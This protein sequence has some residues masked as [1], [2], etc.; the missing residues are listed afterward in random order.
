MVSV[1][2]GG[3][4]YCRGRNT[5]NIE[6]GDKY[7]WAG[8][9]MFE[10]T[11]RVPPKNKKMDAPTCPLNRGPTFAWHAV[12]HGHWH[13]A[14]SFF[15]GWARTNTEPT[16]IIITII[17]IITIIITIILIIMM[18]GVVQGRAQSGL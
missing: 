3:H 18:A 10:T 13:E 8:N 17:T 4:I 14:A 2:H 11:N 16:L 12:L 6:F 1:L 5:S 15:S 9:H 7:Y